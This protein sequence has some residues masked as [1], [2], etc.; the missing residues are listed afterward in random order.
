MDNNALLDQLQAEVVDTRVGDTDYHF[1]DGDTI[2]DS[3]GKAI[4][5]DGMNT[6]EVP[7][8]RDIYSD[9]IYRGSAAGTQTTI[10][11]SKLARERGFTEVV[12]NDEVGTYGRAIGDLRN[13]ETGELFSIWA[14]RNGLSDITPYSSQ[15]HQDA[16]TAGLSERTLGRQDAETTAARGRIQDKNF[17]EMRNR[18]LEDPFKRDALNEREYAQNPYD[19]SGVQLRSL[20][21][22]MMNEATN[23]WSTSF[24]TALIGMSEAFHGF[25]QILGEV[26][27]NDELV[28][29]GEEGAARAQYRM[30]LN[31][32]TTLDL[33][34]VDGI[35]DFVDYL[36]NN[37]AMSIPYMG[38]TVASAVTGTLAGG[39]VGTVSAGPV[40]TVAGA[41]T[42]LGVGLSAPMAIYSG[43]VYNEQEN[44]NVKAALTSGF[45]QA[46]LDRLGL[47]GV[48][49]L[50]G[51]GVK[52]TLKDAT[53]QLVKQGMT[54]EAA[55]EKVKD[56]S[57]KELARYMD[58]AADFA[59]RQIS[60][61][62]FTR[63]VAGRFGKAFGAEALTEA[64]QEATA[65][66]GANW[67]KEAFGIHEEGVISEEL[68]NRMGNAAIAGGMLGGAM[69]GTSAAVDRG[70]WANIAFEQ[71][72]ARMT[73]VDKW[74]AEAVEGGDLPH[75]QHLQG[76]IENP[77]MSNPSDAIFRSNN[78]M[79]RMKG[80]SGVQRVAE[81]VY[82]TPRLWR[83]QVRAMFTEEILNKSPTARRVAGMYGGLLNKVH[84][85][86]TFEEA[87][88]FN[89]KKWVAMSGNPA[90]Y[91]RN[92]KGIE[93]MGKAEK[94]FDKDF[95]R[96]AKD[97]V[98]H[99]EKNRKNKT[100]DPFD[101]SKYSK[102]EQ[103]TFRPLFMKLNDTSR[104]MLMDQNASWMAGARKPKPKFKA[105]DNYL[106]RYKNIDKVKLEQNR[107]DFVKKL[108]KIY[109]MPQKDA[110]QLVT[111]I[112]EGKLEDPSRDNDAIFNIMSKG[113]HPAAAKK[114]T[115]G[116]SEEPELQEYFEQ[117]VRNNLDA[118]F[119][120]AARFEAY[121]TY[122]GKDK[123][124]MNTMLN[125]MQNEGVPP[126]QVDEI[127]YHLERYFQSESGNYKRPPKGSMGDR[128]LQAQK[129]LLTVSLFTSLPLSAFSSLPELAM[130]TRGLTNDQIFGKHGS[131]KT[132]GW[133]LGKMFTRGFEKILVNSW[134]GNAQLDQSKVGELMDRLGYF[135][136]QTGAATTT[137][138]TEVND[139]RKWMVDVFFKMNGLQGLTN[140]T[141]SIRAAQANDF[142]LDKF[143]VLRDAHNKD[144]EAYR[145]AAEQLRDLGLDIPR[146]QRILDRESK[147]L[148]QFNLRNEDGEV[149][150]LSDQDK[151]FLQ[152][153]MDTATFRFVNDA[154]ALPGADNRPLFYQDPR[155]ALLTQFNG[156]IA[157]LTANHLPKMWNEYIKRGS[158]AMKYTTF[159][160]MATMILLGFVSQ[161]FKDWIR[162]GQGEN[163]YLNNLQEWRRAINSSGLLGSGER[164]LNL[165]YPMYGNPEGQSVPAWALDTALGEM[166][167]M[168]PVRRLVRASQ[169]AYQGD[170]DDAKYHAARGTP[171]I[172]P[173]NGVAKFLSGK[174]D[175]F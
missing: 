112:I 140:A 42:G 101:W 93:N 51:D 88:H 57:R 150:T 91:A 1:I 64:L 98:A 78:H 33:G 75:E 62:N 24:D 92:Y 174:T 11:L 173:L 148:S 131:L 80:R 43:Q 122:V 69:G 118:A 105:I 61:R 121:H 169:E 83:P 138:A 113:F 5:I 10:E 19:F 157:T 120:S 74:A 102:Q 34:E 114:R 60:A 103:E 18:G 142:I 22:N 86:R 73:N 100:G 162:Y 166:P 32:T 136:Q 20:D 72:D 50:A 175:D 89:K 124:K 116:M 97:Y 160:M 154:V 21:R 132:M 79:E 6:P 85:G 27:G 67:D 106:L 144:T 31:P 76:M 28:R 151:Q 45:V 8:E 13:P 170:Y 16:Y 7:H 117:N 68:L 99:G 77:E 109:G 164:V 48:T 141:R 59:K 39:A 70:K 95:N 161:Y 115:I 152:E 158:P 156:F 58:D 54:R 15:R 17:E 56:A 143:E 41:I 26:T 126:E 129:N 12:E 55:L 108:K 94:E 40:G 147:A 153:Q 84:A 2:Q 44:K 104:R 123:W 125:Q 25:R 90:E 87:K 155:F 9:D 23:Q 159:Q 128:F 146:I 111:D 127:A 137:G 4:R 37:F 14:V 71:G 171:I 46:T 119:S 165:A 163:P 36:G 53:E 133:E 172:G 29:S 82:N 96:I 49:A 130:T 38:T 139:R 135:D 81:I 30:R 66:A 3:T 35:G 149:F 110:N 65:Y 134:Q 52:G 107:G 145:F 47:K 168:S 167:A 63:E